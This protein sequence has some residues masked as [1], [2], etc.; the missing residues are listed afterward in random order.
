MDEGPTFHCESYHLDMPRDK[1]LVWCAKQ[2][3]I[4]RL[5]C[6]DCEFGKAAAKENAAAVRSSLPTLDKRRMISAGLRG[7]EIAK[8]KQQNEEG[9]MA[10]TGVKVCVDCGKEYKPASNVQKR[11]DD[12]RKKH[13]PAPVKRRQAG[14]QAG[15]SLEGQRL[16][17]HRGQPR[18][19]MRGL[20]G[21]ADA[22]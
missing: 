2:Y 19:R 10:N 1:Q 14:R 6:I 7:R 17:V 5:V 3:R 12:C 13:K 21:I 22:A 8:S 18:S 4:G 9:D 20:R 11:C 16:A 15:Q